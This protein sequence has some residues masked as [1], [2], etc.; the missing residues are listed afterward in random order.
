MAAK[1]GVTGLTSVELWTK[2][3]E[4]GVET[5]LDGM[6]PLQ[7]SDSWTATPRGI[8]YTTTGSG[9][10][11]VGFYDF[12]SHQTR[13]VRAGRALNV[14]VEQVR[15]PQG[16]FTKKRRHIPLPAKLPSHRKRFCR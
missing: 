1:A 15:S 12:A 8:Y 6:P 10:P 4:G 9:S 13:V 11:T 2:P 5:A 3:V 14:R 16:P 7:F